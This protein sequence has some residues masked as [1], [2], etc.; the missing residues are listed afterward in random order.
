MC[1]RVLLERVVDSIRV[2][3]GNVIPHQTA[4][5]SLVDNDQV[6]EQLLPAVSTHLSAIPFC[7]GLAG[8]IRVG[9]TPRFAVADE[10]FFA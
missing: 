8:L 2:I 9:F 10:D 5:M 1:R 4:Q 6:I 7:R 3:I